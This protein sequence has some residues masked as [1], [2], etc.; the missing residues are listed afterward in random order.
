MTEI[1]AIQADITTLKVD[2]IV[3]A[4]NRSLL[5]GSGVDGAIHQAAGPELLRI[6]R[7][8]KGCETGEAKITPGFNLSARYVIHTVG[9]IWRG[10]R[11]N[12][13]TLLANS[14]RN[15]L[16]LAAQNS[17]KTIAFPSISTGAYGYPI[18]EATK[19]AIATVRQVLSEL[20]GFDIVYFCCFSQH[21]LEIYQQMLAN[22]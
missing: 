21:D 6:C 22:S 1:R 9:P 19:I 12:E 7:G 16:L 5:G 8:L 3:N 10:G 2:A 15:S 11:N 13:A 14:Y 20:E 18:K 17:V 4:A